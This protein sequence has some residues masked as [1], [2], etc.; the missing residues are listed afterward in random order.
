MFNFAG[1]DGLTVIIMPGLM[2]GEMAMIDL[3]GAAGGCVGAWVGATATTCV[4]GN[5]GGAISASVLVLP[6]TV[7]YAPHNQHVPPVGVVMT[8]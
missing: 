4:G 1:A 7:A 3:V 5:G 2:I 8:Q 6:C